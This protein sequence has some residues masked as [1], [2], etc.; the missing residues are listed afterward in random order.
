MWK[1]RSLG[2]DNFSKV[3]APFS[4]CDFSSMFEPSLPDRYPAVRRGFQSSF[5]AQS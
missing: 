3:A 1:D 2:S 4:V 5:A